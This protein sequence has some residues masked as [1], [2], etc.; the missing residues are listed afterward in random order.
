MDI[1]H[2]HAAH[3]TR[4]DALLDLVFVSSALVCGDV[5]DLRLRRESDKVAQLL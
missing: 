3:N 2:P 1:L 5:I 4:N